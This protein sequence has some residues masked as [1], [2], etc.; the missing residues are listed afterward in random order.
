MA[1]SNPSSNIPSFSLEAVSSSDLFAFHKH[2]ELK[3]CKTIFKF[4]VSFLPSQI[5]VNV[6]NT[7][8][9]RRM[10]GTVIYFVILQALFNLIKTFIFDVLQIS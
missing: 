3:R 4:T 8:Y 1:V 7:Y 9:A 6:L 2:F 10:E 5:S